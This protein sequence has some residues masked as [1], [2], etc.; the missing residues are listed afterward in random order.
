[1]Q[2][3]RLEPDQAPNEGGSVFSS[4]GDIIRKAAFPPE[5]AKFGRSTGHGARNLLRSAAS[6]AALVAQGLFAT[7]FPSDCRLCATPLTNISR[8]PVC[9]NC[10]SEMAPIAGATCEICGER[11]GSGRSVLPSQLCPACQETRPHFTKAAA[12][13]AYDGGLRE[14]IHLLKYERVEPAAVVLGRMLGEAIQNL[15]I[16]ADSI[17][18]IPVPLH[19][20]KRRERGFNQSELIARAALKRNA[21]P[22]EMGAD[23]LERTRP[24][25][26]QIGLTRPQRVENIRGAFRVRHPSR[27]SGRNVV[28]VDDVLT[29]GTT[30]SECARI[31]RK[32]GAEKVWVATV[33]RTLKESGAG[34][35]TRKFLPEDAAL[36]EASTKIAQAS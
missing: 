14:L 11:L 21:F 27:V 7:L 32:A 19:S 34:F 6:G 18:V 10:L 36:G 31:L 28:L 12:Y 4:T 16:R 22:C 24:T 23:V 3:V 9:P 30:V 35:E 1:V 15:N 5:D 29:T 8:V 17:L 2:F 13:G 33:A 20:S 25:V 26:S